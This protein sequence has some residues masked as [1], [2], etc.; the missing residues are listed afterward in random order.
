MAIDNLFILPLDMIETHPDSD[1]NVALPPRHINRAQNV[2]AFIGSSWTGQVFPWQALW[3]HSY[4]PEEW[5]AQ[6]SANG[7]VYLP[8]RTLDFNYIDPIT[9]EHPDPRDPKFEHIA[10]D[11]LKP[12]STIIGTDSA[13]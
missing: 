1:L 6:D 3:D 2:T 12:K 13:V 9:G 7:K 11:L 4:W 8:C 10:W 5:L